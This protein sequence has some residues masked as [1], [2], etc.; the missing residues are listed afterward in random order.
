VTIKGS[1]LRFSKASWLLIGAKNTGTVNTVT[2]TVK[3]SWSKH[4]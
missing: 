1:T 3:N 4:F 2:L